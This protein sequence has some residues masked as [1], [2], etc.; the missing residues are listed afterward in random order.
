[1]TKSI[2]K[3]KGCNDNETEFNLLC[4]YGEIISSHSIV[5]QNDDRDK[6][7]YSLYKVL[8]PFPTFDEYVKGEEFDEGDLIANCDSMDEVLAVQ[9]TYKFKHKTPVL[10]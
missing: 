1:M 2:N 3:K 9:N 6:F 4:N 8:E 10:I 5:V 7:K